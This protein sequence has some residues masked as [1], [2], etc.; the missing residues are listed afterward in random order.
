MVLW[1]FSLIGCACTGVA[2][3]HECALLTPD[4]HHI[5]ISHPFTHMQVVVRKMAC[6]NGLVY[7]K[8]K[9]ADRGAKS[10]HTTKKRK[11]PP[12]AV[13]AA[14]AAAGGKPAAAK[15]SRSKKAKPAAAS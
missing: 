7:G 10:K 4:E 11:A 8:D 13:L 9:A 14:A 3:Q 12:A 5:C 15:H 6:H 2:H 1:C